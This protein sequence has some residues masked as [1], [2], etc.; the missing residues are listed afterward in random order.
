MNSLCVH[1]FYKHTIQEGKRAR[2]RDFKMFHLI[3]IELEGK[4]SNPSLLTL[5]RL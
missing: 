4:T 2:D 1:P 5:T 3:E